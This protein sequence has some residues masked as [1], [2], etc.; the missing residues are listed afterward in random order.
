MA[1]T[2]S[3]PLSLRTVI[4]FSSSS[5]FLPS[6]SC[7]FFFVIGSKKS[8]L[9]KVFPPP[10]PSPSFFP[11]VPDI[12]SPS[13]PLPSS[14]SPLKRPSEGFSQFSSAVPFL[15]G[16]QL[17]GLGNFGGREVGP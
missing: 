17:L 14:G 7:G 4:I 9:P 15:G 2:L 6:S 3:F 13:L 5:S 11:R 8:P 1:K 16:K 10:L 12:F